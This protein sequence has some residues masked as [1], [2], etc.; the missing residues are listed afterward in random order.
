[1]KKSFI[2]EFYFLA[3]VRSR[4]KGMVM[5]GK[6]F[7]LDSRMDLVSTIT[8]NPDNDGESVEEEK[9]RTGSFSYN[10]KLLIQD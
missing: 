7:S 1:M 2:I 3:P 8:P 9:G 4:I 5:A 10:H 6:Q